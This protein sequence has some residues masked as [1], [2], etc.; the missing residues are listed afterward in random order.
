MAHEVD[1]AAGL[2]EVGRD[3]RSGID[4]R[5][6]ESHQHRR[7]VDMLER[8]AHRVLAADR[9]KSQ[10]DLH[11]Q[12]AEQCA[13]R[14]APR[15]GIL[16]HALEILLIRVTHP[17]VARTRRHDLRRG[18]HHGIGRAVIG[19]PRSDEGIVTEGHDAGR[20]G[21]AV[22]RKL[23]HRD[24]R[25]AALRTAAE[26]H[27]YGRG[28]DRRV[29][30]FDKP[31]LRNDVVVPE[32]ILETRGKRIAGDFTY[33]RIAVFHLADLRFGIMPGACA[34][35]E[36]AREVHDLAILV[37]HPHT[38]RVGHVGHLDGFDI[39]FETVAHERLDVLRF[40][41]YR[42][43]FLRLADGQLRGVQAA[44]LGLHAVEVDVQPVGQLADGDADAA[45]AEVV[46]FLDE[47][48][49]LRTA[50]Q[51][52]ELA[53][54][55]SVALLHLAAAGLQRL[56]VVLFRRSGSSADA[57][58]ARTA[59]QHD[60]L[61]ARSGFLAADVLRLHGAHHGAHFET[62]GHIAVVVHLAY[63][64]R[65]QTDLVAVARITGRGLFRN[66]ALREFAFERVA[67][68]LVDVARPRH[69]HR[70]IDVAAA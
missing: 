9:R 67:H 39:L 21:V 4:R 32:V 2:F 12:R 64:G 31:P 7:N 53:L 65:G 13:E 37:E 68:L 16:G 30:H 57:V 46:R 47:P 6:A 38:G 25:L 48:R 1:A 55:R 50:E 10:L 29:E 58:A 56:G 49:H 60:D 3:D 69:A 45:R 62:L 51:T 8:A 33:E 44:V 42:H 11:L 5:D 17:V 23:L 61:V 18:F 41:D 15:F 22:G 52:F 35:D 54:L 14:L 27:Q 66:H 59:A 43:A 28:A 63:V 40:D 34:V 70:L 24:L 26:G 36:F 19:A 20:V